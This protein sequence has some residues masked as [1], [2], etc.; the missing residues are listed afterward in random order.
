MANSL[1]IDFLSGNPFG[2]VD[3]IR[4]DA[5][6]FVETSSISF[7]NNSEKQ[8]TYIVAAKGVGKSALYDYLALNPQ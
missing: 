5:N 8:Y 6:A 3:G 7:F 4:D 1:S 2:P